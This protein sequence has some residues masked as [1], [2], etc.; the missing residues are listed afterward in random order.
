MQEICNNLYNTMCYLTI[1]K[2]RYIDIFPI[3]HQNSA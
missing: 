2:K 1:I 3:Q